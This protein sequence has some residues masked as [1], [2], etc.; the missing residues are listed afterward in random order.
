MSGSGCKLGQEGGAPALSRP[1]ACVATHTATPQVFHLAHSA[2]RFV[3]FPINHICPFSRTL[4]RRFKELREYLQGYGIN[5]VVVQLARA[6]SRIT[7]SIRSYNTYQ[8]V[9]RGGPLLWVAA[10]HAACFFMPRCLSGPKGLPKQLDALRALPR[11]AVWPIL[12]PS[13]PPSLCR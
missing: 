7:F 11:C 6:D 1:S 5:T 13:L 10:Q 9:G 2:G 12:P 4:P 3:P 8:Q